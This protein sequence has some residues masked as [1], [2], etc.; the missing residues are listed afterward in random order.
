MDVHDYEQD[1][2]TDLLH[3]RSAYDALIASFATFADRIVGHRA[4]TLRTS[5]ARSKTR[6]DMLS[7]DVS[8]TSH[9]EECTLHEVLPDPTCSNEDALALGIDVRQFLSGFSSTEWQTCAVLLSDSLSKGPRVA[10][11][12][13][14]TAYEH[15]ERL[16][17]QATAAGLSNYVGAPDILGARQ[18]SGQKALRVSRAHVEMPMAR[19]F[20]PVSHRLYVTKAS[21]SRWLAMARP[22][23]TLEYFRVVRRHPDCER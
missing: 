6:R 8:V 13:R 10:G 5:T 23:Q 17:E 2:A 9:G 16:R 19:Q 11:I 7:L 1:L 18:V 20:Q 4:S 3:R 22:G 15:I 12:H 21:L 14:W